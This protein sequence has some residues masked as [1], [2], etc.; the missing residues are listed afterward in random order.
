MSSAISYFDSQNFPPS[1]KLYSYSNLFALL[2]YNTLIHFFIGDCIHL[3]DPKFEKQL[4][5][6]F[7]G[8]FKDLRSLTKENYDYT[9]CPKFLF[10]VI[11]YFFE[12]K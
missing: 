6:T 7:V 1:C 9:G 12:C 10:T 3:V 11:I 4:E 2:K 8:I 5:E